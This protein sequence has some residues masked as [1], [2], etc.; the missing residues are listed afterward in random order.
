MTALDA[1]LAAAPG[2]PWEPGSHDCSAWPARW[3]GVSW[4]DYDSEPAGKAIVEACGGLVAAWERWIGDRLSRT[5]EPSPGDIG[6]I[7]VLD[8]AGKSTQVGAI[9]TGKRWAFVVP[10]GLACAS[11]EP[12][13]VWSVPCRC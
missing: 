8:R 11:A 9:F 2:T 12:L 10:S 7:P 13:A 6:V 1:Y 5:A 4:P 3:A